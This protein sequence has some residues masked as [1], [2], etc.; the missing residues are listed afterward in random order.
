MSNQNETMQNLLNRRSVRSFTGEHVKDEDLKL[1]LEAT[2]RGATSI[3]GQQVSVVYVRDQKLKDKIF[4]LVGSMERQKHIAECDIFSIFVI[5]Y[6]RTAHAIEAL[7]KQQ[8]I[9]EQAEGYTVGCVDVGIALATFQTAARALGYASTPVGLIRANC[10][11][12]AELLQ[13]P[14]WT[15]PAVGS[16]LGVGTKEA[17]SAPLKPRIPISGFAMEGHYDV[18]AAN[19]SVDEYEELLS[20]YRKENGMDYKSSYR[21]EIAAMYT[22]GYFRDIKTAVGKQGFL[23]ED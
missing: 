17:L 12:I 15:F 21:E 11:A 5:D 9:Q 22:Q 3:N 10:D 6:S 8:K 2:Q 13:L 20:N 19:K 4:E 7:G 18:D 1:I 14:K 16:T 23:F